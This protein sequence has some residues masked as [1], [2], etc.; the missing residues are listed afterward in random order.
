MKRRDFIRNSV[1]LALMIKA[2]LSA[3]ENFYRGS[4]EFIR[5]AKSKIIDI[6]LSL[7]KEGSNLVLKVMNGK[8]YV[9]DPYVRYP[10]DGGIV[11]N[12]NGCRIFFHA[13]RPNEYGH[14]HAFVEDEK[15]DLVHLVLIL[16]NKKGEPT[17]LATVNTWVTGD[18]YV[19]PDLLKEYLKSFKMNHNS[20]KEKRVI[21]FVESIF[22]AYQN[23]IFTLF[24]EREKWIQDYA[25]KNYREPFEDRD[26]EVL[27]S[28]KISI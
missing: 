1:I 4:K 9:F 22:E 19:K 13:H 27:S 8:K 23:E 12:D 5:A 10:Y 14:F 24:D 17:A 18:K 7:K 21:E 15:G 6:I 26:F 11:D 20:Y 3:A 16:M 2:P 28:L 25:L